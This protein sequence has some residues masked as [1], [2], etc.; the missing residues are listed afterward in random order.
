MKC[1]V[2]GLQRPCSEHL[3]TTPS[4]HARRTG[5]PTR[6]GC[7]E[8]DHLVTAATS[9]SKGAGAAAQGPGPPAQEEAFQLGWKALR[10]PGL[11]RPP[12]VQSPAL[13]VSPSSPAHWGGGR[14]P[15][16]PLSAL[17]PMTDLGEGAAC[18]ADLMTN[19]DMGP[20]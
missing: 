11:G 1:P 7:Q 19:T 3:V 15:L 14:I 17:Q 13:T 10:E 16:L 2:V 9:G 20:K 6:R 12:S 4:I 5:R 8:A 18:S